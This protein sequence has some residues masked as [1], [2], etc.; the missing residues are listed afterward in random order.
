V[1]SRGQGS[2]NDLLLAMRETGSVDGAFQ[3]VFGKT[4]EA[5]KRDILETFWRRYS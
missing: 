5:M 4:Y 2:I 1:V 3:K